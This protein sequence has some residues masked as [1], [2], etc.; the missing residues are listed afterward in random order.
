MS[1]TKPAKAERAFHSPQSVTRVIQILEALSGSETALGLAQLA[2]QLAAP[3][4]SVAALLRGLA[5]ADFVLAGEGLYRL[6]P[7]AYGLGSALLQ[8]RQRLQSS[9]L[10]REGLQRLAQRSGETVLLAVGDQDGQTLSYVEVIESRKVV[11][12]AVALGDR[13]PLY[14]TAGGRALLAAQ[15]PEAVQR[16]LKTLRPKA[17]CPHTETD[18][19]RLAEAIAEARRSGVAQTEDQTA[20]GATGTAAVLRDAGGAV[21]GALIVAAPGSRL[22]DRRGELAQL[23]RE[24]AAVISRSLGY[25]APRQP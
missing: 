10:I 3:K 16:Y 1:R 23:V 4:S 14:C 6:G 18:K 12:F 19:R 13:R 9:T 17:L 2:R 24:E 5:E 22:R 8:A 20:E 7:A 11:R 21:L 15:A 25:R